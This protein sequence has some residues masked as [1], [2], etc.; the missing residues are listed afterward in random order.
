MAS[1]PLPRRVGTTPHSFAGFGKHAWGSY[2]LFDRGLGL[3]LETSA[4]QFLARLDFFL[5]PKNAL[6][7][8]F[9]V[10]CSELGVSLGLGR[11]RDHE[12]G[13]LQGLATFLAGLM[14]VDVGLELASTARVC[15]ITKLRLGYFKKLISRL[16]ALF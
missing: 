11:V 13:H 12:L 7:D 1:G 3:E 8:V 15:H 14:V 16:L 2:Q 10:R 9:L 4:Q 6:I 5:E